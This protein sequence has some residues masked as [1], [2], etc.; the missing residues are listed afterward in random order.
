M[1]YLSPAALPVVHLPPSRR[2]PP[3]LDTNVLFSSTRF[4]SGLVGSC[5]Y[6][7]ACL[8]YRHCLVYHNIERDQP[9]EGKAKRIHPPVRRGSITLCTSALLT[10]D[11]FERRRLGYRPPLLPVSLFILLFSTSPVCVRIEDDA[12][13]S[14][15]ERPVGDPLHYPVLL[16][17]DASLEV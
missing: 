13:F 5:L 1:R 9:S 10:T 3:P 14:G 6:I 15:D 4:V 11:C 16:P 17:C 12:Y 8:V 2:T 7:L